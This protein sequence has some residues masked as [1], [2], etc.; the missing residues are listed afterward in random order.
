LEAGHDLPS[1]RVIGEQESAGRLAGGISL[2]VEPPGD[3]WCGERVPPVR[4]APPG[5]SEGV[6]RR[7]A[8]RLWGGWL[9]RAPRLHPLILTGGRPQRS[10]GGELVVDPGR[11][12][13]RDSA[14]WAAVHQRGASQ[15]VPLD[16]DHGYRRVTVAHLRFRVW[17][18]MLPVSRIIYCPYRFA[19]VD[20]G[21]AHSQQFS[22]E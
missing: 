1:A 6:P 22:D 15:A 9:G 7:I 4:C 13:L 11:R 10:Q 18:K 16:A 21:K 5:R 3:L 8:V 17:L 12:Q 20:G 14:R 19:T 2:G